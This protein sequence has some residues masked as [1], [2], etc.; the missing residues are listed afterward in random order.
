MKNQK[1]LSAVFTLFYIGGLFGLL[2][3][4]SLILISLCTIVMGVSSSVTFSLYMLFLGLRAETNE[5]VNALAGMSQIVSNIISAASPF[6]IGLAFDMTGL[7]MIPVLI[8][9]FAGILLFLTGFVAGSDRKLYLYG[10][11]KS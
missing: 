4:H 5:D 6:L 7:W 10:Q 9:I 8:M 2:L 11:S 3:S 1:L